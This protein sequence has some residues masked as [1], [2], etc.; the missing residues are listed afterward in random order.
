VTFRRIGGAALLWEV[1]P[2]RRLINL[3]MRNHHWV[4][5]SMAERAGFSRSAWSR[6]LNAGEWIEIVPGAFYHCAVT[7]SWD[8]RVR[9]VAHWLGA[10]AALFGSAACRWWGLDGFADA[11]SVSFLVPRWRRSVPPWV[12]LHTTSFWSAA[13]VT[14]RR[15]VR[16]TTVARAVLDLALIGCDARTIEQ[17]VDSAIH[18]R[19]TSMV[20]LVGRVREVA[21]P[22]RTGVPLVR[23]LL[24]DSGG[25]SYLERRFLRLMR[26]VGLPR[27]RCQVARHGSGERCLRV[28]FLFEQARLVVEVSGRLGHVSD[29]DRQR[30][31]RRRNLLQR[32]GLTVLEFTTADVIDEPG[33][34][35]ETVRH[36]L[37]R[38]AA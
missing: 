31:A 20:A 5:R 29:R 22:G 28:D 38:V 3:S 7:L 23:E 37:L 8:E 11:T 9:A 4:T 13:D 34:V 30:D 1:N 15:G 33:Y 27:P 35:A 25:E 26:G 2:N 10:D 6:R 18:G 12:E 19:R 14:R 17:A 36:H 32:Q 16:V 21:G 24:L